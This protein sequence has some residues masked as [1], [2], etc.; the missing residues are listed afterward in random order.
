MK[1]ANLVNKLA[2]PRHL[3]TSGDGWR[4]EKNEASCGKFFRRDCRR[5][6]RRAG[7]IK[8]MKLNQVAISTIWNIDVRNNIKDA[9]IQIKKLGFSSIEVAYNLREIRLEELIAAT[10]DLGIQVVSVH[11]FCPVPVQENWGRFFT[12]YYRLSS[13]NKSERQQAIDATKMTID[14]ANSI[15]AKAVVIH[16]GTIEMDNKY[17]K[18]LFQLYKQGKRATSEYEF[19]LEQFN[20]NRFSS[21]DTY[22][23]AVVKSFEEIVPHAA[24]CN[25][26]LGMENRYYPN[27]IPDINEAEYLLDI[28]GKKG[29]VYWHDTG[30]ADVQ[31]KLGIEMPE[32]YLSRFKDFK[33][34]LY[35]CHIHDVKGVDDHLP[36]FT[37]EID[38]VKMKPYLES[39]TVKVI[40][41]HQPATPE[42]IKS[43]VDKLCS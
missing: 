21:K 38:F 32:T 18:G 23:D 25:I 2:R 3:A 11:N 41:A 31:G 26:K 42:Q 4:E 35:G 7:K 40:E 33:D 12:D 30:H 6:F 27:E 20:A 36:P 28:F 9:L 5:N 1:S 10:I 39:C 34:Y 13:P 24:G 17:I 19:Q 16:A 15:G 29:L 22:M 14:I 43:A 8:N 37:G